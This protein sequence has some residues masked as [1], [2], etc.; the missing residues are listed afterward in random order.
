[1]DSEEK[2]AIK[3]IVKAADYTDSRRPHVIREYIVNRY[4]VTYSF[5]LL[6]G[7][8]HAMNTKSSSI[9]TPMQRRL[10]VKLYSANTSKEALLKYLLDKHGISMTFT[11]IVNLATRYNAEHP[12]APILRRNRVYGDKQKLEI[13]REYERGVSQTELQQRYGYSASSS[14]RYILDCGNVRI[15]SRQEEINRKKPYYGF[16]MRRID[17]ELKAYFLGLM[18]TD[19]YV[20]ESLNQINLTT[21]DKDLADFLV[22]TIHMRMSIKSPREFQFKGRTIK[23]GKAYHLYMHGEELYSEIL[24][25]GITPRK[26]TTLSPTELLPEEKDFFPYIARGAIDGDGWIFKTH[27]KGRNILCSGI[28]NA[29]KD[30]IEWIRRGLI[31]I[32]MDSMNII[33]RSTE[34]SPLGTGVAMYRLDF[35]KK[36]NLDVLREKVYDKP[37]GMSRKYNILHSM[38]E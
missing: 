13:I 12:D 11:A 20:V 31:E 25:F 21:T 27:A 1:M 28:V 18:M 33:S 24:R 17:S 6:R 10:I 8:L 16:S 19:G 38:E 15:R 5:G 7:V 3:R 26:T 36:K 30:F 14:I 29:S 4:G 32:G 23:Q 34:R 2:A 37:F 22:D 9:F 35:S